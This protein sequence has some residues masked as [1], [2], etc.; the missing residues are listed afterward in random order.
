MGEY[1]ITKTAKDLITKSEGF[2]KKLGFS[3]KITVQ[4]DKTGIA[5]NAM[6]VLTEG[7][8]VYIPFEGRS[9]Y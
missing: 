3:E 4:E 7:V 5:Q 6:S 9:P 8:E 1:E 2:L